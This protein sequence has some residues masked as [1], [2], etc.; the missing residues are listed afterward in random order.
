MYFSIITGHF[1]KDGGF[2]NL[3]TDNLSLYTYTLEL[4]KF[5][6]LAID[7]HTDDLD[8]CGSRR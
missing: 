6:K 7:W 4:A 8:Q 5:N 2:I 1:L 3:K